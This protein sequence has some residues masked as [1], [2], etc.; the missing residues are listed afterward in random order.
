M[1]CSDIALL[2]AIETIEISLLQAAAMMEP[3]TM[4]LS[5]LCIA[6]MIDQDI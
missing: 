3:T 5:A 1:L 6:S 2:A 4:K